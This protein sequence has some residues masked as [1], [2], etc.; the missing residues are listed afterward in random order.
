MHAHVIHVK[1]LASRDRGCDPCIMDVDSAHLRLHRL[2]VDEA[3]R[4]VRH[5]RRQGELW[6]S[7]FPTFEQIDFLTA[8]I[9]DS[10]A[11][12]DPG[13]FGLFVVTRIEDGLVMGGAGFF[14]PP[15]EFGAVEIVVELDAS[16]RRLGYGSEVIALLIDLARENGADFVI[17]STSV[18]NVA[19]QHAIEHGGLTEVVRDESIV[20]YAVDLRPEDRRSEDE[21]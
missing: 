7:G 1:P 14:G 13:A 2:S 15:D 19:G 4:I 11:R 6:A 20:H 16:V 21:A 9:A 8:F 12:R 5:E 10:A 3:A 18:H 17:T